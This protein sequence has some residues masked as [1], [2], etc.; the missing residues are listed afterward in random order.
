MVDPFNIRRMSAAVFSAF[1]DLGDN[2]LDA[3]NDPNPVI[4]LRC[5]LHPG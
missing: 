1:S 4:L 2:I 3:R 5:V